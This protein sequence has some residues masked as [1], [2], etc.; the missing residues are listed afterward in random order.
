MT[1]GDQMMAS[2][3]PTVLNTIP[4]GD[5]REEEEDIEGSQKS[6]RPDSVEGSRTAIHGIEEGNQE[7]AKETDE[8][9]N[10]NDYCGA[11]G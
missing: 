3:P 6:K 7:G 2:R 8:R 1:D 4:K 11:V 9:V 5:N 10:G